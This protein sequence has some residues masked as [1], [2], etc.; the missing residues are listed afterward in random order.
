LKLVYV[1]GDVHGGNTMNII[2]ALLDAIV[3]LGQALGK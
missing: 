1:T 2:V 3:P